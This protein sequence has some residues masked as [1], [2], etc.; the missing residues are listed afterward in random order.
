MGGNARAMTLQLTTSCV[1]FHGVRIQRGVEASKGTI[2]DLAAHLFLVRFVYTSCDRLDRMA[3]RRRQITHYLAIDLDET[4]LK[5]LQHC[6]FLLA[7]FG[8]RECFKRVD[9]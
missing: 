1:L 8:C 6:M 9:R 2:Q 3:K 4:V 5:S 7:F